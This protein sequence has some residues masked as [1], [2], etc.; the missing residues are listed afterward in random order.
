[1]LDLEGLGLG[2]NCFVYGGLLLDLLLLPIGLNAGGVWSP[3]RT[4]AA[5]AAVSFHL[6]NHFLFVI[7]TFPFVMIAATA[8][9]FD[10]KWID[11]LFGRLYQ[12]IFS[13]CVYQHFMK[14]RT[15]ACRVVVRTVAPAAACL[16]L[17]VH[18]AVPLECALGAPWSGDLCFTRCVCLAVGGGTVCFNLFINLFIFEYA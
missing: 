11:L 16:F 12:H 18:V 17:A 9:F 15:R 7:E 2:F 13:H 14:A 3:L 4:L 1:L 6:C 8:L 10:H 5:F